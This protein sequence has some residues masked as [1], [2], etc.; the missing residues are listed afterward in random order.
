MKLEPE[1]PRLTAYVLGELGPDDVAAIEQA[2]ASDP[3]LQLE[4][5]EIQKV[6]KS[7]TNAFAHIPEKLHAHQR[8]N[9]LR[10]SRINTKKSKLISFPSVGEKLKPWLIPACA[11]AVLTIASLILLRMPADEQKPQAQ[12]KIERPPEVDNLPLP[13]PADTSIPQQNPPATSLDPVLPALVQR[14]SVNAAEYPLLDLPVQTGNASYGWISKSILMDHKRPSH[15]TVRLEEIL[16]H[17]PLRLNGTTAIA[18]SGANNWHPDLRDSGVSAHTATLTTEMIACPWKPSSTLLFVS[19]R[20][21][22]RQATECKVKLNYQANSKNVA[23]YRLLGF[24]PTEG[25][26]PGTMPNTLR[27]NSAI[28]LAIEIE[29]SNSEKDLGSLI[30][31]TDDKAAPSVSLIRTTDTEP[32]DDARF[33]AL[34]CTYAQ[35]LAGEQAGLIDDDILSALARETASSKLPPERSEFLDLIDRSLHL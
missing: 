30:W 17:F 29:P 23:R 12:A 35:W 5:V 34:V 24:S 28:T 14:G 15:N 25:S 31:S 2:T 26:S 1:D 6:Q 20:G 11:A 19:L 33:A 18:R 7:L 13:G 27:A 10:K 8:E 16:N 32:S 21:G 22:G 3:D 4:V 9:I